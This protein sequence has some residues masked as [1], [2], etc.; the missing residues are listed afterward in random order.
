MTK[1]LNDRVVRDEEYYVYTVVL[2]Q[3]VVQLT[4]AWNSFR[5]FQEEP[6]RELTHREVIHLK[7]GLH[8]VKEIYE[9]ISV[10]ASEYNRKHARDKNVVKFKTGA[11]T[12]R[13]KDET[14]HL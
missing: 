1:R 12:T 2:A 5:E 8:M 13:E 14:E 7:S 4:E 9:S 6:N 3:A 10:V 11:L